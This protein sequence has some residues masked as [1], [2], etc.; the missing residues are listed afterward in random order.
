MRLF[1]LKPAFD[2][3][4]SANETLTY[5]IDELDRSLHTKLTS[6]LIARYTEECNEDSRKQLI[7]TT[8]DVQ[9]IDQGLFRRD[10]LWICERAEDGSSELYAI[11]DFKDLRV[12]KDIQK[13]TCKG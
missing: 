13:V 11:T 10:E 12:D 2:K 4:N 5:V 3:L 6:H 7:F 9:L 8:H 1:D